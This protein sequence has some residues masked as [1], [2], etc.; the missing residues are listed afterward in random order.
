MRGVRNGRSNAYV[1]AMNGL[2]QQVEQ[3]ARGF[4]TVKNFVAIVYHRMSKLKNL[5][6]NPMQPARRCHSKRHRASNWHERTA[7]PHR[8]FILGD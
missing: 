1:E 4:R 2:L 8:H 5:Q 6:L 7:S 3:A